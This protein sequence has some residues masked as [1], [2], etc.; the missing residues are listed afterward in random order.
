MH[1]LY[2]TP[3]QRMRVIIMLRQEKKREPKYVA[4]SHFIRK[5]GALH[6]GL[7]SVSTWLD[8][9][10]TPLY[11]VMEF[12]KRYNAQASWL[13]P[14]QSIIHPFSSHRVIYNA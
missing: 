11:F 14:V 5:K 8:T 3:Q 10:S 4:L 9:N 2:F 6:V 7:S 12:V 1:S 13:S